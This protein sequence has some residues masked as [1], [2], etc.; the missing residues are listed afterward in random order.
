MKQIQYP[1]YLFGS[2]IRSYIRTHIPQTNGL[3]VDVPCGNGETSY[4]LAD[5]NIKI[6]GFD[7][8]ENS[9]IRAKANYLKEN[10][11]FEKENIFEALGK[12]SAID[13]LC[14][15]NSFFLLPDRDKLLDLIRNSIKPDGY[16]FFIIPNI[17]SINYRNFK[18]T[19]SFVNQTELTL[20]EFKN[21]MESHGLKIVFTKPLCFANLYGRKELRFLSRLAP[22][23]L[24]ILNYLMT[25]FHIGTPS[26]YLVVGSKK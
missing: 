10:L 21:K 9:I 11:T 18:G 3:L 20:S 24:I 19:N 1:Q 5:L 12:E 7:L 8:D 22:Y 4:I 15:I 14:V 26:Y 2:S 13:L 17:D 25:F 6:K 16:V 23:Y